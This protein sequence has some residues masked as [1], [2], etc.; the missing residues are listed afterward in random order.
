LHETIVFASILGV[1]FFF[2][3]YPKP[4]LDFITPSIE[5]ILQQIIRTN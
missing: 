3:L 1:V 5:N 4:I 2:G